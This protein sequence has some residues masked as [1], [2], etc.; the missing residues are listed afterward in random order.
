MLP[1]AYGYSEWYTDD[2]PKPKKA[3]MSK[4]TMKTMIFAIFDSTGGV[5]IEFVSQDQTVNA[6]YY[7]DMPERHLRYLTTP[8]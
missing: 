6:A 3:R 4:S 5:H 8:S 2:S 1:E 7:V